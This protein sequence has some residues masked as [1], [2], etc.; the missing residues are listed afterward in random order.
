M[1]KGLRIVP[2]PGNITQLDFPLALTGEI[3]GTVSLTSNG[4]KR[5][6][7]NVLVELVDKVGKVVAQGRSG[8]DGFFVL[9]EV[10]PG[11]YSLRVGEQ[12]LN[13]LKLR[14]GG[15]RPV[16]IP[17]KGAFVNG[18]DFALEAAGN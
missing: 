4:R 3:D 8:A 1:L 13:E 15:P 11:D 6:I 14:Y 5:G 9:V 18:Q 10:L 17:P 2:R 12:Q 7:G 16:T